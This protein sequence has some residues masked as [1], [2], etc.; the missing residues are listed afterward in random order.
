MG[1]STG[2]VG[3]TAQKQWGLGIA[4]TSSKAR[5]QIE[6]VLM[7]TDVG[8]FPHL[9]FVQG[10]ALGMYHVWIR[11]EVPQPLQPRL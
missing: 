3:T 9:S 6:Q 1:L 5:Y 2:C 4:V 8:W 10:W 7:L 11:C